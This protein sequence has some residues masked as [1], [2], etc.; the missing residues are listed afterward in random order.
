MYSHFAAYEN[1]EWCRFIVHIAIGS[2]SLI[3]FCC[4]CFVSFNFF[5]FF[6]VFLWVLLTACICFDFPVKL[7]MCANLA[8]KTKTNWKK[9]TWEVVNRLNWV[10]ASLY[11]SFV[12]VNFGKNMPD[13]CAAFGFTNRRSSTSLQF[14]RIPSAK[15]HP[16]R[17]IK[18]VTT[19]RKEKWPVKKINK[20]RI[21]SAHF[22]TGKPL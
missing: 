12:S 15:R 14:Y 5:L 9:S 8:G 16:E 10:P 22:V 1:N 19:M 7:R 2:P 4:V 3:S 11:T 20:A 13:S 21:C 18:W 6:L 17:R